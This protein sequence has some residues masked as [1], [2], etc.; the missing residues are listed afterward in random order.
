MKIKQFLKPDWRK[1][2]IFALLTLF[3]FLITYGTTFLIYRGF[4]L[5]YSFKMCEYPIYSLPCKNCPNDLT[6]FGE[7]FHLLF[8]SFDIIVFYLLSC[9]I[10][11]I[12]DK[13][14]KKK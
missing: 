14:K 10:V 3:S 7:E 1:I 11:W 8:L 4:P 6:C 2:V 12:Y 13:V 5:P 9:L